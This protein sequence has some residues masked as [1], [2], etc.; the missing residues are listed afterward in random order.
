MQSDTKKENI[1]QTFLN[2]SSYVVDENLQLVPRGVPGELLV[3]GPLVGRGYHGRP[4]L[5]Q[6]AFLDWEGK[7]AYRTGDLGTSLVPANNGWY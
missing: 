7:W 4:D 1:G 2:C 6:K 3:A 5:T